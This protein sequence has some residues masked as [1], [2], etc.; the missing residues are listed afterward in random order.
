MYFNDETEKQNEKMKERALCHQK[1]NVREAYMGCWK[2]I[3][4]NK[5]RQSKRSH[6]DPI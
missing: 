1:Q 5:K 4:T 3:L 2:E 6:K